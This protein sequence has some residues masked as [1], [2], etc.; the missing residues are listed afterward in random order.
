MHT[1]VC[2]RE[3]KRERKKCM[4][5][6]SVCMLGLF[7]QHRAVDKTM[8]Y[9]CCLRPCSLPLKVVCNLMEAKLVIACVTGKVDTLSLCVCL[10]VRVYIGLSVNL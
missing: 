5:V 3:C 6:Q 9:V 4:C 10:C 8:A 2:V 1:C 7:G